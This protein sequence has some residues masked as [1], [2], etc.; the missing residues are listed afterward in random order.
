MSYIEIPIEIEC[1]YCKSKKC[2]R[3]AGAVIDLYPPLEPFRCLECNQ[4]FYESPYILE[5]VKE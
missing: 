3:T 2:P 5:E 4:E 1:P